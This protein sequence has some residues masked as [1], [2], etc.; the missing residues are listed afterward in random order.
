MLSVGEGHEED[1]WLTHE[2]GPSNWMLSTPSPVLGMYLLLAFPGLEAAQGHS[3]VIVAWTGYIKVP[4]C[5][6]T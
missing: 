3:L 5:V 4:I 6:T 1:N 2:L